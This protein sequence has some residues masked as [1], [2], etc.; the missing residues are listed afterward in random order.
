M[1]TVKEKEKNI[2]FVFDLVICYLSV[3]FLFDLLIGLVEKCKNSESMNFF[4]TFKLV[5][6]QS[7]DII[8]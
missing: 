3:G 1:I 6:F 5:F 2:Y 8:F 7:F 4:F